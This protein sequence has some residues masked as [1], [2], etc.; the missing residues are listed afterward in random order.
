MRIVTPRFVLRDFLEAD[1]A[2]FVGYQVDARYRRLYDLD[3][4]YAEHASD[5]F[6]LFLHWQDESPRLNHQLGIFE[7]G[8]GRL[9]GS[10][11]LRGQGASEGQA[12][13]GI[14]L[15]PDDWGRYRLAVEAASGVI[16]FG[17]DALGLEC[18]LGSTASG[19]RRVESL[20]RWFGAEIVARRPGPGWM[21]ARNWV[22]VDWALPRTRWNRTARD[23][24]RSLRDDPV[25]KKVCADGE[26]AGEGQA[27]PRRGA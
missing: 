1:R 20:A 14:E 17:F 23:R 21:E 6:S 22:E 7:R 4:T 12:I 8:T 5:L 11:G 10:A 26:Q 16:A 9:C 25:P 24:S 27:G 15:T 2:A 3:A 18:I 13:F 19:N